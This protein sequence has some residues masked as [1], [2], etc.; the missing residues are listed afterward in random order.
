MLAAPVWMP[1]DIEGPALVAGLASAAV[2]LVAGVVAE[3]FALTLAGVVGLYLP[4]TVNW[5]VDDAIGP[6]AALLVSGLVLLVGVVPVLVRRARA[7]A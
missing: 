2:L 1:L 4:L 7:V 6:P 5:Y 3:R